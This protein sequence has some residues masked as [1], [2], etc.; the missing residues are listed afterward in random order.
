[1]DAP[2]HRL[3]P[4]IDVAALHEIE[5]RAGDGGF[6]VE[7]HG[8]VRIIPPAE[9]AEALEVAL[10]LLDVARRKLAAELT[11]LRRRDLAFATQFLFDLSFDGQ[12]V[13]IPAGHVWRVMSRHAPGLHD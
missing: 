3:A 4:A 8:Q 10:M 9:D 11:E 1:M 13:T 12:P 6:I 7:A 5:K 2:I